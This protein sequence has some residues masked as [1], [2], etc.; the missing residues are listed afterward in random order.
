MI[1][2]SSNCQSLIVACIFLAP[3]STHVIINFQISQPVI[4]HV[5]TLIGEVFF[6]KFK[7]VDKCCQNFVPNFQTHLTSFLRTVHVVHTKFMF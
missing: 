2:T 7:K 3:S 5:F 4:F 6:S 1:K